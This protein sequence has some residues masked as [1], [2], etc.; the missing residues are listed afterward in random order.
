MQ[1]LFLT[2]CLSFFLAVSV[3]GAEKRPNFVVFLVD[4]LG[5]MDIGV[6]NPTTFYETPNIDRLAA[7]GTRFTAGYAACCVCSPTRFSMMTGK[8]PVRNG[9]TDWFGARRVERFKP[10]PLHEQLDLDETTLA[11]A[12]REAGYQTT[13]VG[14]WHLGPTPEFWPENQGFDANIGGC[15][16]GH[17]PS[18]FAPYKNPRLEDGPKG[19]FLTE[20]LTEEAIR[21]I[22][23]MKGSPFLLYFAFYQVHT[24]LQAREATIQK[25]RDKAKRLG[26]P[27]EKGELFEAEEQNYL[28][29]DPRLIRRRQTHPVYAAM[30]ESMDVAVGRVVDALKSE[31][32]LGETIICFLSDNGGAASMTEGGPTSNAPLRAGKGWQY[33]GGIRVPYII[34]VP[35]G[36]ARVTETPAITNDIYP[37][38]LDLA[39]LPLKPQQHLDG[40]SLKPVLDGGELPKRELYWHYPHYGNQGGFPSGAVRDGDWKLIRRYEDGRV[41]LYNLKDDPS[42]QTDLAATKPEQTKVLA[43]KHD[44]WLQSTGAKFLQSKDGQEPWKPDYLK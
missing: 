9:C 43:D 42:E 38:L 1:R 33:E 34:Y 18:Y 35:G 23:E 15:N 2:C 4:D 11:E 36:S 12:L 37:T 25:Y 3:F 44:R 22:K 30:V 32:L 20:R 31:G 16:M 39:G 14:K 41:H 13:F 40:V 5:A 19:E 29:D 26:L 28:S 21:R 8:Y 27:V 24:P 6:Y 10:A 7:T 17:P